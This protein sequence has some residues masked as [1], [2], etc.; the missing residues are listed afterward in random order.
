MAAR[1]AGPLAQHGFL[2]GDAAATLN[3]AMQQQQRSPHA[4]TTGSNDATSA[5]HTAAQQGT[6]AAAPAMLCAGRMADVFI[7]DARRCAITCLLFPE[8]RTLAAE[9]EDVEGTAIACA[10]PH[11]LEAAYDPAMLLPLAAVALRNGLLGARQAV[12]CG[13]L[14]VCFRALAAQDDALR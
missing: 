13:L 2:F 14:A 12:E 10:S 4:V 8:A 7:P 11:V 3:H 1:F 6:H 9:E 5:T